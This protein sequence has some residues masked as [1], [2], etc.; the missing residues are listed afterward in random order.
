MKAYTKIG[1]SSFIKGCIDFLKNLYNVEKLDEKIDR[2]KKI[3]F[4]SL[5]FTFFI[6][7][8]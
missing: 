3:S 6:K 1:M 4:K 8:I 2:K 7:I 5:I